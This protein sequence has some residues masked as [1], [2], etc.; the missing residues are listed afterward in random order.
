LNPARGDL[1]WAVL[2]P[3]LGSEQAGTRPVLVLQND[4][5]GAFTS[6]IVV[7][8]LTTV[9]RR[10]QLPS[11]AFI[12][13]LGTG[14]SSNSVA[15]CHQLRVIDKARLRGRLGGVPQEVLL[16]V[17]H[18]ILFTLGIGTPGGAV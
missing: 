12:P 8:P 1:W 14:L 2:D 3:T 10:A 4:A 16:Q 7:V 9:L 13:A 17:E 18:A 15:L 5:I 11:S 6:T